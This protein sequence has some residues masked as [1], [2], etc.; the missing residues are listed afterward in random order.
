MGQKVDTLGTA[1]C[2]LESLLSLIEFWCPLRKRLLVTYTCQVLCQLLL[3]VA[4][5]IRTKL[6]FQLALGGSVCCSESRQPPFTMHQGV[7]MKS[8]LTALAPLKVSLGSLLSQWNV[9]DG[10]LGRYFPPGV[11]TVQPE[12]FKHTRFCILPYEIASASV[13]NT[14][15]ASVI[16]AMDL[17]SGILIGCGLCAGPG[18]LPIHLS[19]TTQNLSVRYH[20]H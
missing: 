3:V 11:C 17:V 4:A 9:C 8:P 14:R 15:A 12:S 18:V 7:L 5:V 20:Q 19:G 1:A 13:M 16:F 2:F 6:R 10:V